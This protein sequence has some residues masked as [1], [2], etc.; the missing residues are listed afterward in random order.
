MEHEPTTHHHSGHEH[1]PLIEQLLNCATACET[2]AAACLDE[3]DVTHMA[4]CIEMDRDCAELCY[5]TAK[6][7]TRDSEFAHELLALCEKA[8]RQCADECS[9]HE[10][11]HCKKCADQCTQ[12]ADA[13]NAHTMQSL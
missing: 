5:I 1:G 6:L 9:K 10:H 2:C 8:C 3:E 13:C 11:E 4:Q 7:L 12:C